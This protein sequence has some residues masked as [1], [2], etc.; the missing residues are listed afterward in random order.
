MLNVIRSLYNNVK[1][2]VKYEGLLSSFFDCKN[3]LF[4]GEVLSP[5]L[6]SSYVNDCEMQF[7]TD[8]CPSINRFLL[9]Y[10][11]DMVLTSATPEGTQN[12]LDSLSKY[13][14]KWDLTV[15][16]N[17]IEVVISETMVACV[18]IKFGHIITVF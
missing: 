6:F 12:M 17:K 18:K 14:K 16:T 3:G 8:N 13:T 11:D 9:M 1:C 2:C 4:Q 10:A 5:L 7:V 15:N